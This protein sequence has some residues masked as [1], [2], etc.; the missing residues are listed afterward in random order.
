MK[1]CFRLHPRGIKVKK[2]ALRE[3]ASDTH[4][5]RDGYFINTARPMLTFVPASNL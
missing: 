5:L 4:K 2:P 3:P 1:L